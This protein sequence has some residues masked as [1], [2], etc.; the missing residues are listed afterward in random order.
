MIDK[1]VVEKRVDI[2]DENMRYLHEVRDIDEKDFIS[3]FEKI[4][5]SKHSLQETMEACLDIANHIMAAE[6]FP[7]AE[8]YGQFFTTLAERGIIDKSLGRKL[9]EMAKFRNL[10]VH[11]YSQI[12]S[13]ELYRILNENL[14]DI[15]E[16]VKEILRF[17]AKE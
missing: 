16:Y 9:S 11:R 4:Q 17:I 3:N 1:E 2:I 15:E 10:L 13:R 14:G 8:E 5:A 12:S 6:G 7:R